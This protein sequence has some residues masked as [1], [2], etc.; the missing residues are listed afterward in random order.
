[1]TVAVILAGGLGTRLRGVVPNLPKPMA[2]VLGKPF[3]EHLM[4]YW[5]RQ[6][7]TRF[8]I[9]V[10]YKREL[11]KS[12]FGNCYKGVP[13][14]YIEEEVPLGTGGGLLLALKELNEPI[15]LLNGDT[16]FK[17][18]LKTLINFHRHN[19]AKWTCALFRADEA[20]RYG[21]VRLDSSK[22]ICS[23]D[24]GNGNVGE[25][26]NGGVYY[27]ETNIL[28]NEKFIVGQKYSLEDEV[29]PLLLESGIEFY[30]LEDSGQFLDIGIPSDYIRAAD[31]LSDLEGD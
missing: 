15:L 22:R 24:S 25:L 26:A 17:I 21:R 14:N 6:G 16:L 1:M 3:L 5:V 11:I 7:V 30:G 12:Y 4:S 20:N 27:L 31:I 13:V 23:L 28:K 29:I 19:N 8:L 9:S 10:G 2:Q 18:N